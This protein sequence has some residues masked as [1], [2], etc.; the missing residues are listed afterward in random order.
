VEIWNQAITD[1][2]EIKMQKPEQLNDK[3]TDSN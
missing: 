2:Q 1:M 3:K